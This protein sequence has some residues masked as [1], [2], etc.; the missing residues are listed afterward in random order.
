MP[1]KT[2]MPFVVGDVVRLNSGGHAMTVERVE[3][4]ADNEVR[5]HC[6]WFGTGENAV[7]AFYARAILTKVDQGS[8]KS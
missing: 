8:A 2:D 6:I 4:T 5:Y 7:R 1:P 3:T